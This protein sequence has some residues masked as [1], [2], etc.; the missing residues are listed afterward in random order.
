MEYE[1]EVVHSTAIMDQTTKYMRAIFPEWQRDRKELLIREV[2]RLT[3]D[4]PLTEEEL[5]RV[6]DRCPAWARSIEI[7]EVKQ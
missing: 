4:R 5:Q 2:F 7:R 3:T 6:K 1:V